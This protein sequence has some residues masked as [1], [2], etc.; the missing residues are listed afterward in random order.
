MTRFA[1]LDS[2]VRIFITGV[3]LIAVLALARSSPSAL[4][5]YESAE[6]SS[7]ATQDGAPALSIIPAPKSTAI[8]AFTPVFVAFP[9]GPLGRP[10]TSIRH[11]GLIDE[12]NGARQQPGD[13]VQPAKGP[14]MRQPTSPNENRLKVHG[15]PA[16]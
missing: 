14:A 10:A 5:K 4:R 2:L 7:S 16:E 3:I 6:P 1:S 9:A 15:G 13:E 12:V 8:P 11:S